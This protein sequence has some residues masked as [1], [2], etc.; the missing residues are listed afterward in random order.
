MLTYSHADSK[1]RHIMRRLESFRAMRASHIVLCKNCP[2]LK[3]RLARRA[4]V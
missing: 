2:R 4:L 1:D 3:I